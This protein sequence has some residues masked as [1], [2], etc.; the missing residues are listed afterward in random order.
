MKKDVL[1]LAQPRLL[2]LYSLLFTLTASALTKSRDP[3]PR[4]IDRR[5][6]LPVCDFNSGNC[7]DE[8]GADTE[9]WKIVRTHQEGPVRPY[10]RA[11][12]YLDPK[13]SAGKPKKLMSHIAKDKIAMCVE[14]YYSTDGNETV[15]INFYIEDE[16]ELSLAH[17]IMA[18]TGRNWE[19]TKFSCCLPNIKSAKKFVV[20]ATS[21]A[22]GVPAIDN[23]VSSMSV[24]PCRNGQLVCY[25]GPPDQLPLQP[26]N[27]QRCPS[28]QLEEAVPSCDFDASDKTVS[29]TCGWEVSP[30]WDA[31]QKIDGSGKTNIISSTTAGNSTILSDIDD[32]A[33]SFC[34]EIQFTVAVVDADL[35]NVF[36]VHILHNNT[37]LLWGEAYNYIG[38]EK[39]VWKR[40]YFEGRLPESTD[41]QIQITAAVEG[42]KIDYIHIRKYYKVVTTPSPGESRDEWQVIFSCPSASVN[43]LQPLCG[44]IPAPDQDSNSTSSG[45]LEVERGNASEIIFPGQEYYLLYRGS[46]LYRL[47]RANLTI[48]EIEGDQ[49]IELSFRYAISGS[50]RLEIYKEQEGLESILI[51]STDDETARTW[52]YE[53]MLVRAKG[54]VQITFCILNS[55]V[56][57]F[58][59]DLPVYV[60]LTDIS[61]KTPRTVLPTTEP[62]ATTS[63]PNVTS[64]I[65]ST[66]VNL[67]TETATVAE[68]PGSSPWE[69]EVMITIGVIIF[70]II[71][72]QIVAL[73][74]RHFKKK[75]LED[76]VELHST[77]S[78][79]IHKSDGF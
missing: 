29:E 57:N 55:T 74:C 75:Q 19:S 21:T 48:I 71:F 42:L 18:N 39:A 65:E 64:T 63:T 41:R 27:V 45:W 10:D 6:G 58:V 8:P 22:N 69:F 50:A 26:I 32:N 20:E 36:S 43:L 78:S 24:M 38:K 73:T 35:R 40:N 13:E 28:D 67:T 23:I 52:I 3:N 53:T 16:G 68:P 59:T 66:T 60:G 14:M 56:P 47:D 62:T 15:P 9:A 33:E 61:I 34:L 72:I 51:W 7:F 30:G 25:P 44:M 46:E 17:R 5:A 2:A 11:Y 31:R 77:S 37:L 70:F 12:I 76:S 4:C 79:S 1:Y 49:V 54:A